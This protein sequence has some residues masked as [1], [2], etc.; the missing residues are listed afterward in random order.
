M[1]RLLYLR[2]VPR[3]ILQ[4]SGAPQMAEQCVSEA[5]DEISQFR[6]FHLVQRNSSLR[7]EHQIAAVVYQLSPNDAP[8]PPSIKRNF[9]AESDQKTKNETYAP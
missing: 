1:S 6:C 7:L 4:T 8:F 3:I 2:L 9:V 5:A